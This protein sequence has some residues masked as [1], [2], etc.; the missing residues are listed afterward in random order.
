MRIIEILH[1]SLFTFF[2]TFDLRSNFFAMAQAAKPESFSFDNKN[3][4]TVLFCIV[5]A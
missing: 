5:L 4:K 1:S 2:C 3:K